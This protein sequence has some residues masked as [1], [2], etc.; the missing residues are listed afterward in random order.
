MFRHPR[1]VAAAGYLADPGFVFKI[2]PHGFA[3]AAF[4]RLERLPLQFVLDLPRIHCISPIVAGTIF[5]ECDEL[6]MGHD[7]VV[8]AQLVEQLADGAENIQICFFAASTDVVGLPDLAR[9]RGP[10]EW[11]GSDPPRRASREHSGRRHTPGAACRRKH[12]GS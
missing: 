1:T 7:G 10:R 4:E 5:D 11:P 3:D 6:V 9:G 2:P 8:R 12:S